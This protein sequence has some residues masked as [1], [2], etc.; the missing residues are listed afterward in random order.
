VAAGILQIAALLTPAVRITLAGTTSF[1]RVH[2]AGP[3]LVMLGLLTIAVAFRPSVWWRWIPGVVSAAVVGLVYWRI[4]TAPSGTF[5]DIALRRAVHPA[6]GFIPM[7]AAI[8]LSLVAAVWMP[9]PKPPIVVAP[10]P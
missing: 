4:L 2:A 10:S 6:W 9:R 3:A 5:A 7:W 8:S 1:I